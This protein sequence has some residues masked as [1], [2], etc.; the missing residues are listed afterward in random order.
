VPEFPAARVYSRH[1]RQV[2]AKTQW[3]GNSSMTRARYYFA[4]LF[5]RQRGSSQGFSIFSSTDGKRTR[6]HVNGSGLTGC[7]LLPQA[8]AA[9]EH[10]VREGVPDCCFYI[11]TGQCK[12]GLGCKYNHPPQDDRV[13]APLCAFV[14]ARNSVRQLSACDGAGCCRGSMGLSSCKNCDVF[15]FTGKRKIFFIYL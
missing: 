5:H 8:M 9:Y 11:K 7:L 3:L 1:F 6:Q 4:V 10:P 15:C 13:R 12:L 2:R 14:D